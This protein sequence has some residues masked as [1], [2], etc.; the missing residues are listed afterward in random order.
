MATPQQ[1]LM[2]VLVIGQSGRPGHSIPFLLAGDPL[3]LT[4]FPGAAQAAFLAQ[5][6]QVADLAAALSAA[7]AAGWLSL[8]PFYPGAGAGASGVQA[9]VIEQAG[10]TEAGGVAPTQA[11]SAQQLINVAAGLNDTAGGAR[12][13]LNSLVTAF[14]GTV[15]SNTFAPEDLMPG[16]GDALSQGWVRPSGQNLFDPVFSLTAAGIAQAT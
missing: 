1:E 16:Y 11:A 7:V 15:G 9:Y 6:F 2:T 4:R 5:G 12:F 8:G 13:N 14:V 10:F 3:S